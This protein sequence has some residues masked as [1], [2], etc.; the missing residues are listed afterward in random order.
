LGILREPFAGLS[1][2]I[3]FFV[4]ASL[5]TS[6]KSGDDLRKLNGALIVK[7]FK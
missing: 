7:T 1:L 5:M 3:I 2:V 6:F 4:R